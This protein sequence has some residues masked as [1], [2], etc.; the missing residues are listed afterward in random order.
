MD[1]SKDDPPA[2]KKRTAD[3][4]IT[5]DEYEEGDGDGDDA[6]NEGDGSFVKAPEAVLKGRRIVKARRPAAAASSSE[7][8]T[9]TKSTNPFA[10]TTLVADSNNNNKDAPKIFGSGSGFG[11]FGAAAASA[12]TTTTTASGGG[13]G[14][15]FGSATPYQG[16]ATAT[17]TS[18]GFGAFGAAAAA[19]AS[20]TKEGD[21][22]GVTT[23][24]LFDT[25]KGAS[26][27]P[28]FGFGAPSSAATTTTT[29]TT[30]STKDDKSSAEPT[31]K[32]ASATVPTVQLPASDAVH[33]TTGE[34]DEKVLFEERAKA[35]KLVEDTKEDDNIDSTTTQQAAAPCV[36]PSSTS[37]AAKAKESGPDAAAGSPAKRDTKDTTTTDSTT[38]AAVAEETK[39]SET[40]TATAATTATTTH[41]RWQELGVGPL[42]LLQGGPQ[43][44][45]LVQRYQGKNPGDRPTRVLLN[46]PLY[47]EATILRQGDK[48]IQVTMPSAPPSTF[49][50][51]FVKE[52][53]ALDFYNC[54]TK[55]KEHAKALYKDIVVGKET[56]K[57]EE[58]KKEADVKAAS[59]S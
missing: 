20:T 18:T 22:T 38:E 23:K 40:T 30:A 12:T 10:N 14:G 59:S 57:E 41:K 48:Y 17:G 43:A 5:K 24:N 36:A 50:F 27:V 28:S 53:R 29:T 54:L 31:T 32:A 25:S 42:R 21:T 9:T 26:A 6:N 51:K 15:G 49:N 35:F 16:F 8:E 13:F 2:K 37:F 19:A 52:E 46:E 4:Q 47:R 34:E 3:R 11:G 39:T 44:L 56:K 45:R 55:H 58:P 1:N 7:A 33:V